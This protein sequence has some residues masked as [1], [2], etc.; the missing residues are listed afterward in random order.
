M[1]DHDSYELN[2]YAWKISVDDLLSTAYLLN[3]Q[4]FCFRFV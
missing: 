2:S 4:Y 3:F 1:E